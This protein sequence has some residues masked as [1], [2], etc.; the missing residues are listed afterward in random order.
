MI[1][2]SIIKF[3]TITQLPV[4]EPQVSDLSIFWSNPYNCIYIGNYTDQLNALQIYTSHPL[5]Y[6]TLVLRERDRSD[7]I[8]F[9]TCLSPS[10]PSLFTRLFSPY[11]ILIRATV[12]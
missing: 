4:V 10:Y 5:L 3:A 6:P 8:S 9:V 1:R 2:D 7:L 12:D 11:G